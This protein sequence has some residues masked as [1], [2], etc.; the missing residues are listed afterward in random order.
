MRC[1]VWSR[2]AEALAFEAD[3]VRLRLLLIRASALVEAKVFG[4]GV[5]KL[6]T[7]CKTAEE[8]SRL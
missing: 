6:L 8:G 5:V 1:G 2:T 7:L 4:G 3:G